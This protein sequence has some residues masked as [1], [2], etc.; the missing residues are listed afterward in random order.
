MSCFKLI[1]YITLKQN[2]ILKKWN[3]SH[4]F[5][6][7]K[8]E[9]IFDMKFYVRKKPFSDSTDLIFLIVF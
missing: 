7:D 3:A 4:V 8:Q 5:F 9:W 1:D 6:R 2:I